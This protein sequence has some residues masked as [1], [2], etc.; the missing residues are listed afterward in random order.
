M[1]FEGG[2]NE[3]E[4][5]QQVDRLSQRLHSHLLLADRFEGRLDEIQLPNDLEEF[6]VFIP[7]AFSLVLA[8]KLPEGL[9]C[10]LRNPLMLLVVEHLVLR[11]VIVRCVRWGD[12]AKR[13]CSSDLAHL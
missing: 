7:V 4:L 6:S 9:S 2:K 8:Q 12:K 3:L 1:P 5:E 10:P 13:L 11:V